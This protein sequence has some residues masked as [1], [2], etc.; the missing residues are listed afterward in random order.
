[1]NLAP[2]FNEQFNYFNLKIHIGIYLH[3][4]YSDYGPTWID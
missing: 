1:M 3:M 4:K 2:F